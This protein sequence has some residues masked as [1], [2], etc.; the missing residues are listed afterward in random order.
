[1]NRITCEDAIEQGLIYTDENSIIQ[2]TEQAKQQGYK[3]DP[4][5]LD[6]IKDERTR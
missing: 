6:L 5:T 1:M 2:L 4:W 3:L